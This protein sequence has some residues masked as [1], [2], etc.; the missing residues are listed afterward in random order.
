MRPSVYTQ[1]KYI[2][3]SKAFTQAVIKLYYSNC[4]LPKSITLHCQIRNR[5][6]VIRPIG[7]IRNRIIPKASK[8]IITQRIT[9]RLTL[10]KT[11]QITHPIDPP[12]RR[13]PTQPT[14]DGIQRQ[15][16]VVQAHTDELVR[17][18]CGVVAVLR[19]RVRG[20]ADDFG[21]EAA[22]ERRQVA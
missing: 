16:T 2:S 9:P 22:A 17:C 8:V 12:A 3:H 21:D 13:V 10:N 15:N 19:R 1:R 18:V 4:R 7:R 20:A 14:T 6:V 5:P 11:P